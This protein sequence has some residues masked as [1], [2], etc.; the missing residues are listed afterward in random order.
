MDDT[1]EKPLRKHGAKRMAITCRHIVRFIESANGKPVGFHQ[2]PSDKKPFP[3][4]WCTACDKAL[5]KA[6]G[7]WTPQVLERAGFRQ[8]C[9]CCY[10]FARA[11]S[12]PASHFETIRWR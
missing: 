4:A 1:T 12:D 11:A 5:A 7:E 8:L 6:N 3:D 9:P 2:A 10:E